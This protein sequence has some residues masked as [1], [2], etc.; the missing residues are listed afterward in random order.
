M[1]T[2]TSN[3]TQV[4]G[5]LIAETYTLASPEAKDKIARALAIMTAGNMA[6][7]IHTE[8]K[9]PDGSQIGTYS[10]GYMKVRTG[11]FSTNRKISK[12]KNKGATASK[13]VFTKGKNKGAP[14]PNYNRT[15]DTKVIFSLT[16]QMEND[17]S[18]DGGKDEPIKTANGY[19]VGWKNP[20]NTQKAEWLTEKGVGK[21]KKVFP[22]VYNL[23]DFEKGQ[24]IVTVDAFVKNAYKLR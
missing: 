12:G 15:A 2:V 23:S 16:R 3:I 14:R 6:Y 1:I 24:I 22:G 7:R 9:N 13:G 8:G 10:D 19:G 11:Q 21:K 5:N 17:F 20:V 18:L 4:V